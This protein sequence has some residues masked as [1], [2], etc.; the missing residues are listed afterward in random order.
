MLIGLAALL[1]AGIASA[2]T[3]FKT[4]YEFQEGSDGN[5]PNGPL[6]FDAAGAIYGTTIN[7]GGTGCIFGGEVIGC[8]TV[9]RVTPPATKGGDWSETVLYRFKGASDGAF[10]HGGLIF[11]ASGALYGTA[12]AGGNSG[13][14][15]LGSIGC[16]V[17]FKLTPPAAKGGDW[18]ET[19]LYPFAGVGDGAGPN[20]NLIFDNFG[21]LYGTTSFSDA[22]GAC[23]GKPG[24]CGTVFKLSPPMA[25]GAHWIE[26]VLYDVAGD[27]GHDEFPN[28]VIFDTAGALYGTTESGGNL[29]DCSSAGCGMVFKLAPPATKRGK[30]TK[31]V[32]YA[33]SGGTDGSFPSSGVSF[34][35][36]G[37]L[38]GTTD[39]GGIPTCVPRG[40]GC[41]AAFKLIP[42]ATKG[43]AWPAGLIP[44]A[45]RL[46]AARA[47]RFRFW[48][49]CRGR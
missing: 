24:G 49:A 17:V 25:K 48:P 11:D 33:F 23:G 5:G 31:T 18:S 40:S 2:A 28:G 14:P 43:G 47:R 15:N 13:C 3:K 29:A 39:T 37:A 16:G 36:T 27:S 32:L 12:N 46:G 9:F 35:A 19:V 30:W 45:L 8:G 10:P 38:S 34:D 44:G 6:I 42:S 41:G 26:T 4:L 20:G 22:S 1:T 7:G 21:T